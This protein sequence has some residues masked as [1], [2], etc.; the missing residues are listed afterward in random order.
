MAQENSLTR[1]AKNHVLD[2]KE[3]A[4]DIKLPITHKSKEL[5]PT[6]C[7]EYHKTKI[8]Q[9]LTTEQVM[10]KFTC[11]LKTMKTPEEEQPS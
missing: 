11:S 1:E 5:S 9:Q 8:T 6:G 10:S 7:P 4:S 2:I 3:A